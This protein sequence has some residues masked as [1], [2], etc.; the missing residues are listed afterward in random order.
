MKWLA[1]AGVLLT[2]LLAGCDGGPAVTKPLVRGSWQEILKAHAGRPIVVH[3][4]GLTCAP[5]LKELPEWAEMKKSGMNLIMIAADEAAGEVDE[6]SATLG[7]AGLRNVESWAFAD[8]FQERLRFEI[9]PKWRG[10]LPRTILIAKDGTMTAMPGASDLAA[11]RAWYDA[12]K[13]S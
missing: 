2:L 10:E 3:L 6:L 9:D 11:I 1:H 13:G 8:S 12:Q 7:K 4:W 5:C